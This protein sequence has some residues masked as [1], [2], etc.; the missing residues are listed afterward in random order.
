MGSSEFKENYIENISPSEFAL[1]LVQRR[2]KQKLKRQSS[3]TIH[4][5]GIC[6][7]RFLPMLIGNSYCGFGYTKDNSIEVSLQDG[8][9]LFNLLKPYLLKSDE[10][11]FKASY[12]SNKLSR[13]SV[14]K[15]KA[16]QFMQDYCNNAEPSDNDKTLAKL[17]DKDALRFIVQKSEISSVLF[18]KGKKVKSCQKLAISRKK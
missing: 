4:K 6:G 9:Q 10:I 8:E 12:S 11:D 18:D 15:V 16:M 5:D 1:N 14:N 7:E 13:L 2:S 17:L 3:Q